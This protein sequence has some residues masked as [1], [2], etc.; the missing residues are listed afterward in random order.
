MPKKKYSYEIYEN[1]DGERKIRSIRGDKEVG[2]ETFYESTKTPK[3]MSEIQKLY[4][5]GLAGIGDKTG[6]EDYAQTV[7]WGAMGGR[8][9][10]YDDGS[11]KQKAYRIRKKLKIGMPLKSSEIEW[12]KEKGIKLPDELR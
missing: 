10:V 2:F 4:N 9:K 8:P 3:E 7:E 11:E 1:S 6:A 5:E 12:L